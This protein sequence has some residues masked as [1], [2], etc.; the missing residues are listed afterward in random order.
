MKAYLILVITIMAFCSL[1][2]QADTL[3]LMEVSVTATRSDRLISSIPM[4]VSLINFNQIKGPGLIRLNDVLSEQTGIKI[5]PQING[6]GNGVQLQ[7]LNPDYTLILIDGE[8]LIGRYTGTL[9]LNRVATGNIKKIEIV[10]G[11]SSSLYGSDALA[12]VI[13]IIT[14]PALIK[15]LNISTRYSSRNTWDF[16]GM[17]NTTIG[18]LRM[19]FHLNHFRTDGYDLTPEVFGQTVSPFNNYTLSGKLIYQFNSNDE[20]KFSY[21][22]FNEFQSNKFQVVS[23]PDSIQVSGDGKVKDENIYFSYKKIINPR[24]NVSASNYISNYTTTTDL[25]EV[26]NPDVRFYEDRFSQAFLR[27]EIIVGYQASIK[28]KFLL[29]SG[30][31]Y[32]TV[33]SSRYGDALKRMQSNYYSFLQ[34]EFSKKK[35]DMTVGIRLDKN[36]NYST[37]ISPKLAGQYSI[38]NSHQIKMSIGRG[39]KAPDFRQLYMNFRNDAASYSVFGTEVVGQ[40]LKELQRTGQLSEVYFNFEDAQKINAESSWAINLGS[41]HALNKNIKVDLNLF[42]NDLSDLIETIIVATTIQQKNI[43]SYMNLQKVFTQGVEANIKYVINT[44]C[45]I[46]GGYQY[47]EAKDK[48]VLQRIKNGEVFGIDPVTSKTYRINKKD[49]IGLAGRS[50]HQFNIKFNYRIPILGIDAYS[51]LFYNSRFG[52]NALNGNVSGISVPPSDLNSNGILDTRDNLV[53]DYFTLNISLRKN[54]NDKI[55]FQTGV[56]NL[57]NY[58]YPMYIP[59]LIGRNIFINLQYNFIKS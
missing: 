31:I 1:I 53:K 8:P 2:G 28:H 43:Y 48:M 49:Y 13:N 5:V 58:R 59:N 29:G 37:Q 33:E 19:G 27:P 7:G 55:V 57:F 44:N 25:K 36:S 51:R 21:R 40:E 11:P 38:S 15:K 20:L 23:G 52:I 32:E 30:Y 41:S 47:L 10:K 26:E 17:G 18:R 22:K 50:R 3:N 34:Y 9:D 16:N 42:R 56:E 45:D 46:S 12:G 39:F 24:W 6:L 54:W 35:W 4:P 14:D